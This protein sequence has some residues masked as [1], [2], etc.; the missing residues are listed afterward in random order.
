MKASEANSNARAFTYQMLAELKNIVDS[1]I[2]VTIAERSKL[3]EVMLTD[4]FSGYVML[5][6]TTWLYP[7]LRYIQDHGYLVKRHDGR[8]GDDPEYIISW[9]DASLQ[10]AKT[11]TLF[12][13]AN[14]IALTTPEEKF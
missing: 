1:G 11:Q 13:T 9:D 12:E 4:P 8:P 14:R 5:K 7:V 10:E 2:F 6:T 3:G